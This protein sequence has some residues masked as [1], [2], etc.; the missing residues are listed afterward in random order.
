MAILTKDQ[1]TELVALVKTA[2][3]DIL[4]EQGVSQ[5]KWFDAFLAKIN[6]DGGTGRKYNL[7][8][9]NPKS[10]EESLFE[11]V[12]KIYSANRK[13][14]VEKL[15]ALTLGTDGQGGYIVP[16]QFIGEMISEITQ[17]L[18]IRDIVRVVPV[19]SQTGQVPKLTGGT[20][21]VN[22]A[23]TGSYSPQSG[24]SAQPTFGNVA[25][26]VSKWGG[27]IPMSGELD[28]DAYTDVGK[29]V[30]DVFTL[31]ARVTENVQTMIGTGTVNNVPNPIGIFNTSAGYSIKTAAVTPGFD[32]FMKAYLALPAIY[33]KVSSWL[34]NS[35]ALLLLATLKDSTGRA[36]FVPD[37]RELGEF[38]VL[39]RKVNVFDEIPTTTG[40]T[41]VAIGDWKNAYYLFDRRQITMLTTNTGGTSFDTGTIQTRADERFDGQPADTK[42]AVILKDIAVA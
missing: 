10:A 37:P 38:S 4:A 15:K 14:D 19:N 29:I 11:R 35:D 9:M 26:S 31:A 2:V 40:K 6:G 25:F 23:E 18:S 32:D 24:G 8:G 5:D 22:I 33:R 21:L 30:M 27:L 41:K 7:G 34:I 1:Q 12:G 16:T 28:E 3:V 20:T 42:A 39:G 17:G 36:L 13:G